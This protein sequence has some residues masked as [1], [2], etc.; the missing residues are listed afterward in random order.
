MVC[1]NRPAPLWT[2][3]FFPKNYARC[4]RSEQLRTK[5]NMS[6]GQEELARKRKRVEE[7]QKE[8]TPGKTG[9]SRRK[10]AKVEGAE[11]A[12]AGNL[13]TEDAEM[14]VASDVDGEAKSEATSTPLVPGE[15]TKRRRRPKPSSAQHA[16]GLETLP[17][18]IP[19]SVVVNKVAASG[20]VA[21]SVNGSEKKHKGA[22]EKTKTEHQASNGILQVQA[23]SGNAGSGAKHKT[24]TEHQASNGRLQVQA[25]PSN[26]GSVVRHKKSD[27]H[28]KGGSESNQWA[29]SSAL[30]GVLL[31][32]DPLFSPDEK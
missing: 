6:S 9:R 4:E 27:I 22:G 11:A 30:S 1:G 7:Q 10:K 20:N 26:T 31:G 29:L 15:I 13:T 19:A 32:V 21:T 3:T 18:Q 8:M 23:Q 28:R 16:P 2:L 12:V 25:Q 24:K 5:R 14:L 17:V